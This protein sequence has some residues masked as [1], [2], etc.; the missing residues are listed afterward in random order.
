MSLDII[1][2][3]D[4]TSLFICFLYNIFQNRMRDSID[5]FDQIC[6]NEWFGN[7]AMILF[8]NKIDLFREKIKLFPITIALK[9]YKGM[10]VVKIVDR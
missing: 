1:T 8:L 4:Y 2:K 10:F 5:L 7:T 3:L 6:N 9:N